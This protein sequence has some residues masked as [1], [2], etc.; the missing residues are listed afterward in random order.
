MKCRKLG[1]IV[2]VGGLTLGC[3][4]SAYGTSVPI[5]Y[6]A[7]DRS[8]SAN[9]TASGFFRGGTDTT[10]MTDTQSQSQQ[11][12]G[13]GGFAG[14]AAVTSTLGPGSPLAT[15]SAVQQ[16]SLNVNEIDAAGSVRANSNL[17]LSIG[18]ANSS[19][20]TAFHITFDVAQAQAYAFSANLNGSNDPAVPGNTSASIQLTDASG[21]NLF[22]PI[23][24]VNLVNFQTQGT[25]AAGVYNLTLDAQATSNDQ[26]DNFVNYSL[27]LATGDNPL[28]L[29]NGVAN[30]I[31]V[32]PAV[33]LPPAA[34][35]TLL[36]LAGM[37]L[38]GYLQCRARER[39][40]HSIS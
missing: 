31:S 32:A 38:A 37:G 18:P 40:R 6:E 3:I 20:T 19:A 2:V 22:A 25:L 9:S 10:P 13:M 1:W 35:I 16:S 5:A 33:P 27:S 21:N 12:N 23:T 14:N 36:M 7:Q 26:S 15:A 39:L 30:P 17:G 29:L 34:P 11:A 28:T 4:S 8:V 24:T